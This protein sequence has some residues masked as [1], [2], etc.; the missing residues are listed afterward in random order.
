MRDSSNKRR[1]KRGKLKVIRH[2][3]GSH[4]PAESI[5][6]GKNIKAKE[7]HFQISQIMCN[8]ARFGLV[9]A[10]RCTNQH[11]SML[12]CYPLSS[13]LDG[14]P[15]HALTQL[16]WSMIVR[17]QTNFRGAP[18]VTAFRG[19]MMAWWFLGGFLEGSSAKQFPRWNSTNGS[20]VEFHGMPNLAHL[21]A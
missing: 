5:L 9:G 12:S 10:D 20:G 17:E 13:C 8:D 16:W 4:T 19:R 14:L 7:T 1:N 18:V 15:V 6:R 3:N 2:G 21:G 11:C